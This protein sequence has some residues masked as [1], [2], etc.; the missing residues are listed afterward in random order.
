MKYYA[1]DSKEISE[2]VKN[3]ALKANI[4]LPPGIHV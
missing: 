1:I 3:L 4:E 2:T